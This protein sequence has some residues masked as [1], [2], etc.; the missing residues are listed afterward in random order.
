MRLGPLVSSNTAASATPPN[1]TSIT[2]RRE[3][4]NSSSRCFLH[5]Q[6]LPMARSFT[7][8]EMVVPFAFHR[9]PLVVLFISPATFT[10]ARRLCAHPPREAGLRFS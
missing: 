3:Q 5:T 9:P 6:P 8:T 1:T 4:Q 2:H 7:G 10:G